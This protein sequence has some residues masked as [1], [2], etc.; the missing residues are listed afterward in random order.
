MKVFGPNVLTL[1]LAC[2][3]LGLVGTY[4]TIHLYLTAEAEQSQKR[5]RSFSSGSQSVGSQGSV[6]AHHSARARLR[7][8]STTEYD[9]E[10]V[11]GH[12]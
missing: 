7:S 12:V 4:L 6:S 8:L 9:F 1:G 10:T 2:L 11:V 5:V 3:G